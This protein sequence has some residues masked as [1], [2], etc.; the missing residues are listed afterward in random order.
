M[1]QLLWS[2]PLQTR[3]LPQFPPSSRGART[4]GRAFCT[5]V[6]V[7]ATGR[8]LCSIIQRA[9]NLFAFLQARGFF[10]PPASGPVTP[11]ECRVREA[12]TPLFACGPLHTG[13][14][15]SALRSTQLRCLLVLQDG[16][17]LA[18]FCL[19]KQNN[20]KPVQLSVALTCLY[21]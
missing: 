19:L 18:S 20:R 9:E 4:E 12:C 6:T 11:A 7:E 15:L 21:L 5:D 14:A 3:A 1:H 8:L 13:K 16:L 10:L 2:S 17:S